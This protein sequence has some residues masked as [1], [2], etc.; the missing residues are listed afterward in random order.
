MTCN[1]ITGT[2]FNYD[3]TSVSLSSTIDL[4]QSMLD[5]K[6]QIGLKLGLKFISTQMTTKMAIVSIEKLEVTLS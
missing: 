6:T 2:L 4:S 5:Q 3:G 1:S